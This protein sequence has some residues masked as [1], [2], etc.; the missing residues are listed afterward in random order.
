MEETPPT[1]W[2]MVGRG[3][4]MG[5]GDVRDGMWGIVCGMEDRGW[6]RGEG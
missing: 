5:D 4:G 3:W 1:G 6:G 2:G